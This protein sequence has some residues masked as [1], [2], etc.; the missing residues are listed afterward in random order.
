MITFHLKSCQVII[1]ADKSIVYRVTI[2]AKTVECY[3]VGSLILGFIG[4]GLSYVKK[5]R[6]NTALMDFQVLCHFNGQH[7]V[8]LTTCILT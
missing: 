7:S 2:R 5:K 1:S 6:T 4:L 8:T 3:E